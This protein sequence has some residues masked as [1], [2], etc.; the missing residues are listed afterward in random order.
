S[1]YAYHSSRRLLTTATLT[2]AFYHPTA[3]TE[4]YTLSL[5]DALPICINPPTAA[6]LLNES[7][8]LRPGDWVAQNAAN[9]GGLMPSMASWRGSD[10]KSTRL[11]SSHVAISY[12][13]FCLK[14]KRLVS[15]PQ[16]RRMKDHQRA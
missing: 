9:S 6:L 1:R 5:H 3:P 2:L 13:V 14:K 4:L 8:D 16:S 15:R 7:I 10:R 11:N 12:A